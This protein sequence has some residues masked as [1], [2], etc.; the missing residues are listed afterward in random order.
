MHTFTS[1]SPCLVMYHIVVKGKCVVT[2]DK[3][4]ENVRE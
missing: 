4:L 1:Q 2:L 3:V